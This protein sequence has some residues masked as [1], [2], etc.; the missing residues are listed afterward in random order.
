MLNKMILHFIAVVVCYC[1]FVCPC[2]ELFANPFRFRHLPAVVCCTLCYYGVL[3]PLHQCCMFAVEALYHWS[4]GCHVDS[5]LFCVMLL[6]IKSL[7]SCKDTLFISILRICGIKSIKKENI[8]FLLNIILYL[9]R[10]YD[11]E[12][13][14]YTF[15]TCAD[16]LRC[17]PFY[18]RSHRVGA[19]LE[20]E[21]IG[22][23]LDRC[24]FW[25]ESS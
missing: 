5:L 17:R 24:C 16:S 25:N 4:V 18:R 13:C 20:C 9:C 3:E 22:N 8:C 15:G 23:R 7:L 14:F 1:S 10:H 11:F 19:P 2:G 6:V 12:Y 21:R